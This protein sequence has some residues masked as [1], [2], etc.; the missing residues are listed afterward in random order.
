[1]EIG[2]AALMDQAFEANVYRKAIDHSIKDHVYTKI[3][4]L[5]GLFAILGSFGLFLIVNNT[6]EIQP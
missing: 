3:R 4:N 1:M 2:F 6:I 5:L